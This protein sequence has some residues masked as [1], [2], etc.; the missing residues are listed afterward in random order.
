MQ[1]LQQQSEQ[2]ATDNTETTKENCPE[3]GAE[4]TLSNQERICADCGLIIDEQPTDRGPDWRAFNASEREEKSHVGIP[5]TKMMHDD[6][7]STKISWQNKDAN[8]NT[9]SG[10]KRQQVNRLRKWNKRFTAKNSRERSL[11]FALGE[12]NRMGSAL[13]VPNSVREIASVIYRQASKNDMIRGR[14]IE[15]A[16]TACLYIGCRQEGLPVTPSEMAAVSRVE[17]KPIE[18][19]YRK[20]VRVLDLELEPIDP[21]KYLP[22]YISELEINS[23]V[24][25]IARKIIDIATD[26]K[27]HSGKSPSGFAAAA[28][29]GASIIAGEKITQRE[30]ADISDTSMVTIRN[31]YQEQLEVVEANSDDITK[32]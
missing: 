4:T 1:Q 25:N 19:S 8:G 13:G 5:A 17:K 21:A 32:Y 3:C 2:S 22:Q 7:L 29:Y 28:V 24:E 10:R 30:I 14:S 18:R 27:L 15:A 16:A 11:K 23:D 9:L 6:G 12:I 20:F 31:R 26:A